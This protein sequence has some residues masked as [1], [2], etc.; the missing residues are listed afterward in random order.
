MW[1]KYSYDLFNNPKALLPGGYWN[2]TIIHEIGHTLGLAHTQDAKVMG[3]RVYGAK[4]EQGTEHNA[5]PYSTMSYFHY[6]GD[7]NSFTD[8]FRPATLMVDDIK[9]IQ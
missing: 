5:N 6:V 1:L 8:V 7:V 3:D 2:Q 4:F 9:T